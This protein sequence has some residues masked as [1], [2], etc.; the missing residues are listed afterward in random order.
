MELDKTD[1]SNEI[2]S[3][4]LSDYQDVSC[5]ANSDSDKRRQ[6]IWERHARLIIDNSVKKEISGYLI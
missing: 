2:Y 5:E 3:D 4:K 1:T 6:S